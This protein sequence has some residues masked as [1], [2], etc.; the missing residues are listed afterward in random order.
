MLI[1]TKELYT[2]LIQKKLVDVD[3]ITA[4]IDMK[5]TVEQ[6]TQED[7]NELYAL[8]YPTQG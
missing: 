5:V 2:R 6:L 1:N 4:M 7:A 8:L 3:L